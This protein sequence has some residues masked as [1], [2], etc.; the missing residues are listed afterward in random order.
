MKNRREESFMIKEKILQPADSV[1]NEFDTVLIT[2]LQSIN[3]LIIALT[4]KTLQELN[5][6]DI[7]IKECTHN[8]YTTV[9]EIDSI[10]TKASLIRYNKK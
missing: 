8:V 3:R 2:A 1:N 4:E 7:T 6:S 9:S 10:V 5:E